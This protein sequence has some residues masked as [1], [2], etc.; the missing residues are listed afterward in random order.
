VSDVRVSPLSF[1][2]FSF[3][4]LSFFL[5][6]FLLLQRLRYRRGRR[7]MCVCNTSLFFFLIKKFEVSTS[8]MLSVSHRQ[9]CASF[10][11]LSSI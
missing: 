8:S 9:V 4:T 7:Q 10:F 3:S 11:F 1:F 2:L 6:F 5:L